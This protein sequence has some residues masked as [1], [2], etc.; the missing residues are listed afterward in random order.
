M[1]LSPVRP[2]EGDDEARRLTTYG[3]TMPDSAAVLNRTLLEGNTCFGC[4]HQN[5]AGLKIEIVR[6]SENAEVLC[7]RFTPTA[8]MTGFPGIVHGGTVFT[9]LDCLSTWVAM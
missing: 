2:T 3:I 1:S 6:D 4:G 5:H 8:T 7:G 9:A